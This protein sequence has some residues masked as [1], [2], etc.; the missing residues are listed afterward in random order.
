MGLA[1]TQVEH[2]SQVRQGSAP[3]RHL[4]V[5]AYLGAVDGGQLR[6]VVLEHQTELLLLSDPVRLRP[7]ALA[8]SLVL[9]LGNQ[10][11]NRPPRSG[12]LLALLSFMLNFFPAPGC[13]VDLR[14]GCRCACKRRVVAKF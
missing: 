12:S 1:V 4:A 2:T 8:Q 3:Q 9:D 14:R 10:V 13:V 6:Q 5:P 11:V 7:Q